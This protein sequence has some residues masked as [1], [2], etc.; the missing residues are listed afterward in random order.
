MNIVDGIVGNT[1]IAIDSEKQAMRCDQIQ[2]EGKLALT[3]SLKN[4]HRFGR[5][6]S[7]AVK[8]DYS[9]VVEC[10]LNT[11]DSFRAT[12]GLLLMD[13]WGDWITVLRSEGIPLFSY[14]FSEDSKKAKDFLFIEKV[15]FLPYRKLFLI[16]KQM[17]PPKTSLFFLKEAKS[18][19]IQKG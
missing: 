9:H 1:F 7:E 8:Y 6:L 11:G 18:V 3:V 16:L 5:S 10:V 12:S 19:I 15:N 4:G 2:E 13:M 14:D 17:T